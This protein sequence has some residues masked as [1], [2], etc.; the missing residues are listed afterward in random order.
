MAIRNLTRA[1]Q[2][3]ICS[4]ILASSAAVAQQH[5]I[6]EDLAPTPPLG[7]ARWNYYFC[8]CDEQTIKDQADALVSTG[9]RDL[10]YRYLIIQEYIA[11][12]SLPRFLVS[13]YQVS[14]RR[15]ELKGAAGHSEG[16]HRSPGYPRSKYIS[17]GS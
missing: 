11:H 15:K 9:M 2:G 14:S 5:R 10:G 3:V 8:N 17:Y 7:W 1:T 6:A 12:S 4:L 13:L 16:C